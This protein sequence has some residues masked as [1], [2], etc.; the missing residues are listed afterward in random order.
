[1]LNS[2]WLESFVVLCET[3]HF[4]KAASLLNMTQPGVSQHLR[5][6]ETQVGQSLISRQGKGFSLTS[7]GEAVLAV[8]QARRAQEQ[9]LQETISQDD[10]AVGE[11][12]MACSGSFATLLYPE[13][14]SAMQTSPSLS[15]RLEAVPQDKVLAGVLE[16]RF[17]LGVADHDPQ[18]PRLQA[19][20]LGQEELCL[21]IPERASVS[22]ISFQRLEELGF[23]AHPDGFAYADDLFAMNFPDEFRGSDRLRIRSFVNQISQI[24][25]P[26]ARGIGYTLLPRSGVDSYP[27]NDRLRIAPLSKQLRHDLWMISRRGRVLPARVSRIAALIQAVS[28]RLEKK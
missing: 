19:E 20:H 5:K 23:I 12:A 15:I 14:L 3:G 11:V 21:V 22:P 25:A 1:M 13:M 28:D 27:D 6:L 2:Q 4:T 18:H 9:A 16:G 8:G 24:P 10:P 7:A 17:D 26:V